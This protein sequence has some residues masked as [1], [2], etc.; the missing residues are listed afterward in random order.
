VWN[1]FLCNFP[2]FSLFCIFLS[3]SA[4]I[5]SGISHSNISAQSETPFIKLCSLK[6]NALG[7]YIEIGPN[8]F[9]LLSFDSMHIITLRTHLTWNN[10]CSWKYVNPHT[11]PMRYDTRC[12]RWRIQNVWPS[13]TW[14]P[15]LWQTGTTVPIF[16]VKELVVEGAPKPEDGGYNFLWKVCTYP[17]NDTA[18]DSRFSR[19]LPWKVPSSG[20]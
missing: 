9:L 18:S 20:F 11:K 4:D 1:T 2:R 3:Q 10:L 8:H 16:R 17:L 19:R 12:S 7:P 14:C 6:K 5:W 13:L 15:I